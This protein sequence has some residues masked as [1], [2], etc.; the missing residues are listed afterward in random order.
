MNLTHNLLLLPNYGYQVLQMRLH[1][2]ANERMGNLIDSALDSA[3]IHQQHI[4]TLRIAGA[5]VAV[6]LTRNVS[7]VIDQARVALC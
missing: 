4:H 3:G 5:L 1:F 6:I 7:D 2:R